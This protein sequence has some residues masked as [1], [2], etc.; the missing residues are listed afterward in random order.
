MYEVPILFYPPGPH[1]LFRKNLHINKSLRSSLANIG[2]SEFQDFM[3]YSAGELVSRPSKR[4]VRT[5]TLDVAGQKRKYFLKQTGIQ[6]LPVVLKACCR[7][8]SPCSDA[9]REVEILELF[10]DQGI[11]VM[12]H[13]AWG[14]HTVLGWPVRGFILV[15]EVIGSEFV[16]VYRDASLR[17]RRRLMRVYGELMG[18][19]HQRGI[20]SKV[21]PRD[22]KCIS[23]NYSTFQKCLVVIDRERGLNRLVNISL[24]QR[25]K[26]LAEIWI[27]GAFTIGR[28][29]R[30]ELLAFLSGYFAASG[31]HGMKKAMGEKLVNWVLRRTADIL[32]SDDRFASLRPDF[33]EKYGIPQG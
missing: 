20:K 29:E 26:K 17:S 5:L 6:P 23:Q 25:G 2:I 13:V 30:S 7:L 11:P 31:V 15:E 3:N 12:N 16:D 14:E 19:L 28:G 21:H 32:A 1:M 8:Q 33:K 22:L 10:R 24:Q 9:S 27:K 4:N 18:A